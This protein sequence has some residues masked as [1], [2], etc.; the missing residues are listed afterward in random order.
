M[1]LFLL[2]LICGVA[3]AVVAYFIVQEG[4]E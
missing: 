1:S 2:G 4:G 3:L